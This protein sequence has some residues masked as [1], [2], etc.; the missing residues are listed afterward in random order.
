M[1]KDQ[2]QP[3]ATAKPQ[4]QSILGNG[5]VRVRAA[6][7]GVAVVR[8][9]VSAIVTG[10]VAPGEVLPPEATLSQQFAVSRT[11]IRESVKRVEEKGLVTVSQGRGTIVNPAAQWNVLDPDVLSALVDHDETLEVLDE[12]AIVR[13]SLEATM[14][15][16]AAERQTPERT[17]ELRAAFERAATQID[18]ISAYNE[19]DAAFHDVV[20]EQ[21][22]IRLAANITR[23]MFS[24]ARESSRFTGHTSDEAAQVTLEEHL[25]VLEA[26]IAG[27]GDTAATAMREH[28][29]KAWE[30]RRA[31]D[32]A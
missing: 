20:M 14:A 16:A 27:D 19:A 7:L 29:A 25:A 23:I 15:R 32:N 11:V 4:G 26:I 17:A 6:N 22:G 28:I 24:R 30:R 5:V 2:A 1:T 9:L 31:P 21:S 18:D 8:D 3:L 10:E 12:L 13:G